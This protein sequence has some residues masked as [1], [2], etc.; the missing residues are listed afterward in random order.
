[1]F[2]LEHLWGRELTWPDW[3]RLENATDTRSKKN[4]SGLVQHKY[5][6]VFPTT[7]LTIHCTYSV[8]LLGDTLWHFVQSKKEYMSPLWLIPEEQQNGDFIWFVC[9]FVYVRFDTQCPYGWGIAQEYIPC[10]FCIWWW[11]SIMIQL[12]FFQLILY[13]LII[14][15]IGYLIDGHIKSMEKITKLLKKTVGKIWKLIFGLGLKEG[16]NSNSDSVLFDNSIKMK[17]S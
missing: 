13:T 10:L 3:G 16:R 9:L 12:R 1:M 4:R 5:I 2:H 17:I 14:D 11:Y 6:Q 7:G 8:F 15:E